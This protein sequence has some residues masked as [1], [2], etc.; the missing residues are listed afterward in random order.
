MDHSGTSFGVETSIE[1]GFEHV[2]RVVKTV[3]VFSDVFVTFPV[4]S[5][6][7]FG[8]VRI[9]KKHEGRWAREVRST[10]PALKTF[11][12]KSFQYS[13]HSLNTNNANRWMCAESDRFLWLNKEDV[14]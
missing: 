13:H 14:S 10:W 7:P 11:S 4:N 5:S 9:E 1:Y 3:T 2:G 8:E 12:T 6:E